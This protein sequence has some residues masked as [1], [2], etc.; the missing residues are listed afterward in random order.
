MNRRHAGFSFPLGARM[1]RPAEFRRVFA[2]PIRSSDAYFSILARLNAVGAPR[3]GLAIS[4][5]CAP[6]AIDRNRLKRLARESF[7]LARARLPNVDIVVTCRR[8]ATTAPNALLAISLSAH[9]QRIQ[10]RLL[11]ARS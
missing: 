7:R 3:V 2:Q 9:W 1:S 8:T 4:K 5:K 11:C 10:D 6:R